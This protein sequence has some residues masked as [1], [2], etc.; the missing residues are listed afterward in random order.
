MF[1]GT[2]KPLE[3]EKWMAD[4]TNLLEAANIP[5]VDQVKVIKVQL[6][7]IARTWWLSEEAKHSGP[8]SWK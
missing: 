6:T 2:E 3:A 1:T 5:E 8:I 4:V 7:D